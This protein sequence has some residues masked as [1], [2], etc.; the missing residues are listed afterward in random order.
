MTANTGMNSWPT[1]SAD[2]KTLGFISNRSG[3]MEVW[4]KD[5][6]TGKERP[7][8]N[9]GV[10]KLRPL[11]T[12]DGSLITHRTS[13]GLQSVSVSGGQPETMCAKCGE[14]WGWSPNGSMLLHM[15]EAPNTVGLLHARDSSDNAILKHPK[16]SLS[17]ARFSPDGRWVSFHAGTDANTRRVY[18][19]P[20]R[21]DSAVPESE[22]IPITEGKSLDREPRW[23]PEGNLLYFLST[24]DGYNCIW[25]QRVDAAKHP[26][27]EPAA[28]LHF[29]VARRN[30]NASDTGPIGLAVAG[31]RLIIS[32]P[33]AT[34]NIW[35]LQ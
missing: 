14:P 3:K 35:M 25:T 21:S 12:P 8:T 27:G 2:G 33:E 22:W 30:L 6:E 10:G 13:Q 5:L 28:L 26:A 20:F 7:L 34:G 18:V 17:A 29:H 16:Y 9:D 32:I 31:G 23:S 11:I 24:R 4:A 19:A 15:G 1:L